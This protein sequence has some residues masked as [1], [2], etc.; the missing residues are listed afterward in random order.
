[1]SAL[2]ILFTALELCGALIGAAFSIRA[3]YAW[4]KA[5]RDGHIDRAERAHLDEIADGLRYG[6]VLL[7]VSSI[8]LVFL[9]YASGAP[10]QPATT[11]TYWSMMTVILVIVIAAWAHSHEWI[12]FSLAS[13]AVFSG[14]W[15]LLYLIIGFVP[16]V[17]FGELV[18]A[19]IASTIL[20][21]AIL[22]GARKLPRFP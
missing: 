11:G 17:S 5:M 7:V 3:E 21:Y 20:L 13:A 9:S 4:L 16:S 10:L 14:W 15:F 8:A 22:Y 18:G 1:M 12:G 19:F 2:V 6:M